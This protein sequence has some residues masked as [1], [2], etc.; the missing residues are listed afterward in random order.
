MPVGGI[1]VGERLGQLVG[2]GLVPVHGIEHVALPFLVV[3]DRSPDGRHRRLIRLAELVV[4]DRTGVFH[5][6]EL[7]DERA[8]FGASG[9]FD[10]FLVQVDGG[11]RPSALYVGSASYSS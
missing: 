5:P 10:R 1:G 3:R 8:G 7:L 9:R 6:G 2:A 4:T 11:T